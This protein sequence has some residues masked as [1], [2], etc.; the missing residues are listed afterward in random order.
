MSAMPTIYIHARFHTPTS[1]GSPVT[2]ITPKTKDIFRTVAMLLLYILHF[3][4]QDLLRHIA[5]GPHRKG[6]AVAPATK[7]RKVAMLSPL[8]VRN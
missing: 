5:L 2:A 6:T 4:F 7:L 3:V 8:T 1:S